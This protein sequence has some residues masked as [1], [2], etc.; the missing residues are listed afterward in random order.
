MSQFA[1]IGLGLFGRSVCLELMR[2]GHDVI[3]VDIHS[4]L[5]DQIADE[6]THAVIA[7]ASEEAA[8]R[9]LNVQ[10]CEAVVVAIGENLEASLLCTLH[11]KTLGVKDIRVKAI[12][13]EHHRILSRLGVSR[14]VHPEEEMGV[15]TAQ[16]LNYPMVNAYIPLGHNQYVVEILI[17]EKLIDKILVDV[18]PESVQLLL[19]KQ[20][21]QMLPNPDLSIRLAVHDKLI[22]SGDLDALN[23]LAK[24]L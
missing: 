5:V 2:L 6:I 23:K 1:V 11:L 17:S 19:L 9:E 15:R 7:D 10:N 14:I 3:G 21:D 18:L 13:P 16:S 12:T 20:G 4:R 24:V 8:L 22:L